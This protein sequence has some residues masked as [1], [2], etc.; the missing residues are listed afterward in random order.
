MSRLYVLQALS[1]AYN[2]K[3]SFF[4][5]S[6]TKEFTNSHFTQ[7]WIQD[8][9]R[10]GGGGA[11]VGRGTTGATFLGETGGMLSPKFESLEWPFPAF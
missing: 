1:A 11:L 2:S 6:C 5:F 9:Q 4:T 10:G 7:G 8:F 3:L